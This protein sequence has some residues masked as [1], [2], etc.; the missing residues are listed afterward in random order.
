MRIR[1]SFPFDPLTK[2]DALRVLLMHNPTAG[3][4]EH[5]PDALIALI[6]AAG[7]EVRWQSVKE[8]D[9]ER[10]FDEEDDLAVAAGGDGTVRKIFRRLAGTDIPV[11]ILPLGTANNIARSLG[12]VDDV[13]ERLVRAWSGGRMKPY[14][15]A[16]LIARR[17]EGSF[18]ESAG[19]GL[20]AELLQRAEGGESSHSDKIEKGLH[21]L[22]ASLAEPRAHSWAFELDGHSLSDD[23]LGLEMMNVS[24]G[25]PQI[26][27]APAA[28][29]GDGG[30]EVVLIRG[31][32]VLDLRS[33]AEA[34]L[35][36][37]SPEP[38]RFDVRR[39]AEIVFE[40]PPGC[41]VHVDDELL[42]DN[43]SMDPI[44]AVRARPVAQIQVLL[45]DVL[46]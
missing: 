16:S 19:A 37:D 14:D 4:E 43:D 17:G 32:D 36:G 11:T 40:V 2:V 3:D 5:S 28:D 38:P 7:H 9:W 42:A 18:V 10:A 15:I 34:R 21:L 20:F 1:L 22:L 44:G 13:P 39:A 24:E 27:L 26:P 8:D 31:E 12:F 45:P 29:P 33:Y 46:E 35:A 6:E 23:L 25:G 30:L 41:P